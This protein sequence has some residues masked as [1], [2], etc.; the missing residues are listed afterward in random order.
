MEELGGLRHARTD[1][2]NT[3]WHNASFRGFA[4]YL[5][6]QEFQAGIKTLIQTAKRE[7]VAI[8]VRRSRAVAMSSFINGRRPGC[9]RHRR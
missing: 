2:L 6:T 5:Q 3:G 1:S 9:A 7:Q 8:I 4:D